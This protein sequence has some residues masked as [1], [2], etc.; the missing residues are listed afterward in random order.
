MFDRWIKAVETIWPVANKGEGSVKFAGD[1]NKTGGG[2][3]PMRA[4]CCD[5]TEMERTAIPA[6]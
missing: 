4:K 1:V 2:D 5:K 3:H 6:L